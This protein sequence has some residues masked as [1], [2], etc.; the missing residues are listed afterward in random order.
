MC[1]TKVCGT[2]QLHL[3]SKS[4]VL[5]PSLQRAHRRQ[6]DSRHCQTRDRLARRSSAAAAAAAERGRT[7]CTDPDEYDG[8]WRRQHN[9]HAVH[10]NRMEVSVACVDF[11]ASTRELLLLRAR[12]G[13]HRRWF[14]AR[15]WVAAHGTASRGWKT[16]KRNT[17]V[18]VSC[19][20][21]C[22]SRG[23]AVTHCSCSFALTRKAHSFF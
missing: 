17:Q 1:A 16:E 5:L 14:P 21:A 9:A 23:N 13:P 10:D 4:F 7:A 11:P 8:E 20:Q 19:E 2:D 15:N 18:C 12:I 3:L 6:P 22:R